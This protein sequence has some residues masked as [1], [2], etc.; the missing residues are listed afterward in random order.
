MINYFFIINNL[1]DNAKPQSWSKYAADSSA[2]K[3]LNKIVKQ[4]LNPNEKK[5]NSTKAQKEK[6]AEELELIMERVYLDRQN[7]GICGFDNTL[8]ILFQYKDD[9]QFIDFLECH[10]PSDK[11]LLQGDNTISKFLNKLK[12]TKETI[13]EN[14][15]PKTVCSIFF[16]NV[17]VNKNNRFL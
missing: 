1:G 10:L 4:V 13:I 11:R 7:T 12:S 5:L 3:K 8:I 2:F 9:P 17:Y 15:E 6:H 16:V 14:E